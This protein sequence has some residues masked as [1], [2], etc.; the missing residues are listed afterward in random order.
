MVM[1]MRV[2]VC[3]STGSRGSRFW[4]TR[5][6]IV[7]IGEKKKNTAEMAITTRGND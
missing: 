6:E 2:V 4:E 7:A 5:I 3:G 1:M